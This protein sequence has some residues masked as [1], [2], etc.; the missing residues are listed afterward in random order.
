MRSGDEIKTLLPDEKASRGTAISDDFSHLAHA[1]IKFLAGIIKRKYPTA[2]YLSDM[3]RETPGASTERR[4]WK[5]LPVAS[6]I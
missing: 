2:P 1:D 5:A 3:R 6:V 4:R